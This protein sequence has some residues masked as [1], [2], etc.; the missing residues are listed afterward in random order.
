[1]WVNPNVKI[2][3]IPW[4]VFGFLTSLWVFL[5]IVTSIQSSHWM[6]W[7]LEHQK[8]S[9]EVRKPNHNQGIIL[10]STL[11]LPTSENRFIGW[12]E[13]KLYHSSIDSFSFWISCLITHLEE[14]QEALE[15]KIAIRGGGNRLKYV[16]LHMREWMHLISPDLQFGPPSSLVLFKTHQ[17][18]I[19]VTFTYVL[20]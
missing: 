7:S 10:I 2:S 9:R 14:T 13:E 15:I 6:D 17:S 20:T 5:M 19:F 1:M 12:N 4:L 8:N 3:M 11:G 16:F 18:L